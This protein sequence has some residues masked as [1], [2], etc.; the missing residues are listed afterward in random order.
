VGQ[1]AHGRYQSVNSYDAANGSP[2]D[3]IHD[4]D[5]VP[6]PGSE[7]P[8]LPGARRTVNRRDF[9]VSVVNQ[10][11]PADPAAREPNTL[12][13]AVSSQAG[14]VL[15]YRVYVADKNR[16]LTG[17]VGLPEPRLTLASGEVLQGDAACAALSVVNQPLPKLVLPPAQ[18]TALRDQ[19][20][21][22]PTFPALDPP[23]FHR[24]FNTQ[25][26][27]G[28]IYDVPTPG[29]PVPCGDNP[30]VRVGQYAT[31]D[32]AYIYAAV[33]R[34]FGPVLV[35]RGKLPT[36]PPTYQRDPFMEGGT[37]LRYWSLC[38][39]ESLATT[40]VQDCVYDEQIPLDKDGFYTI[41]TS[42]AEDRPSN[43]IER[44]GATWVEWPVQGDGAG[45]PDDGFL[46]VRNTLPAPDFSEAIQNVSK[47]GDEGS[48]MGTYL[49]TG[50]YM[51]R[52]DFE[53]LGC[54][55]SGR[56]RP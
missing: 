22:P 23:V 34:G 29:N 16:D 30:P 31:L 7:N 52:T 51:S 44:C 27:I 10:F 42:R 11:P 40:A 15:I 48:V 1:Y 18:Y 46:I 24:A 54:H 36:T 56:M 37:Q 39:N 8:F 28:C 13:A 3:A 38:Q 33:N 4:V 12:Y 20:G 55:P 25:A 50:E 9:T 17:G 43:A 26:D 35:L 45:H 19:P 47:P 53:A 6:D 5:I 32:N 21:K 49:P 41:V 14:E 2:T